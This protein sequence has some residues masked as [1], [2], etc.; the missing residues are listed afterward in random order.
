MAA[1]L[2]RM[3]LPPLPARTSMTT[4][5]REVKEAPE[6]LITNHGVVRDMARVLFHRRIRWDR[7]RRRNC[8]RGLQFSPLTKQFSFPEQSFWW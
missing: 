1:F 8:V 4:P 6:Y 7:S 3:A 2:F 5:P